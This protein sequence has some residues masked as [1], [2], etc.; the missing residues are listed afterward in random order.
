MACAAVLRARESCTKTM[1]EREFR[2]KFFFLL[3]F[4]SVCFPFP[5]FPYFPPDSRIL[6]LLLW[7]QNSFCSSS[8]TSSLFPVQLSREHSL[9]RIT[10]HLAA[11]SK[12]VWN[13]TFTAPIPPLLLTVPPARFSSTQTDQTFPWYAPTQNHRIINVGK[14]HL[15]HLLQPSA[16][17]HHAHWPRPS[18]SHLHID[19]KSCQWVFLPAIVQQAYVLHKTSSIKG[20]FPFHYPK[21]LL[22]SSLNFLPRIVHPNLSIYLICPR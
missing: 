21:G 17:H 8:P 15:D 12:T 4:P 14:D 10:E 3:S 6:L 20:H 7:L 18:V 9:G 11:W 13:E 2:Q 5:V 19:C 22:N 16:H 1:E